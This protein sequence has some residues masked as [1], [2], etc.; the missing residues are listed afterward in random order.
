MARI[1]V[2]GATGGVGHRLVP[3][4]IDAG[5][6]VTALHRK[7][8]QA[9]SLRAMGATPVQ[10]D[11]MELTAGDFEPMFEGQDAVVF[12]AGAAGSGLE[13]TTRIDGDAPLDVIAAMNRMSVPRLYLVSVFPDAGRGKE[14]K[15][16]FEHYMLAKKTADAAVVAS[17]VD[18]VIL[19]PG[20]LMDEDGDGRVALAHALNYGSVARGHVAA[21]LAALIDTPE[22]SLE[23]LELTDGTEEIAASVAALPRRVTV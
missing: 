20:T 15:P 6:E 2:I 23:I 1:F 3:L 12:S 8:E 19:R 22:V 18:Y 14:I 9:D 17:G 13:R 21:V 5:H 4:L 7:P 16:G 10:G 11:L